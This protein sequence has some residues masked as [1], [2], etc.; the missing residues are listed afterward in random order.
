MDDKVEKSAEEWRRTLTPEQYRVSARRARNAPSAARSG[1]IISRGP[2]SARAAGRSVEVHCRRCGGHL[3]H[4]FQD[5]PAPTGERYC[6]NSAALKK[7][8]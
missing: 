3:G 2:S 7:G 8:R 6:I 1:T 5:G 4:V